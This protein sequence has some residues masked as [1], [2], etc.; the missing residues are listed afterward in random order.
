MVIDKKVGEFLEETLLVRHP[1]L[2]ASR[3]AAKA[4]RMPS[5]NVLQSIFTGILRSSNLVAAAVLPTGL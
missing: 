2:L 3:Y 5:M 1:E 4:E